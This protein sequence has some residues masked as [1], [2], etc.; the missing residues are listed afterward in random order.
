MYTTGGAMLQLSIIQVCIRVSLFVILFSVPLM[1]YA[2]LPRLRNLIREATAFLLDVLKHNMP[3]HAHLHSKVLEIN[4]VT[5]PNVVDVILQVIL[6]L[7]LLRLRHQFVCL[8]HPF[9]G[10]SAS[11]G[12]FSASVWTTE[13]AI[14]RA[15]AL[16][17]DE[18]IGTFSGYLMI[19]ITSSEGNKNHG[20]Y[21]ELFVLVIAKTY[22]KNQ[23]AAE[24]SKILYAEKQ[25][26]FFQCFVVAACSERDNA[27]MKAKQAKENNPPVTYSFKAATVCSSV[28]GT[29]GHGA[30]WHGAGHQAAG[31]VGAGQRAG[32]TGLRGTKGTSLQHGGGGGTHSRVLA[33]GN[34]SALP[35]LGDRAYGAWG[36]KRW[37]VSGAGWGGEDG[38]GGGTLV[39]VGVEKMCGW[40]PGG[41]C[42]GWAD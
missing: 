15:K 36:Q 27:T 19:E 13:E 25:I 3:E 29:Q 20:D 10:F 17:E 18:G 41:V 31:R 35:L 1:S 8:V 11:I 39:F 24:L 33:A 37:A 28:A 38:E 6:L 22:D 21:E 4:L 42:R 5:F 16:K 34:A 2:S 9:G 26:M 7:Y 30:G 32:G 14:R 40:V 12:M 23:Y